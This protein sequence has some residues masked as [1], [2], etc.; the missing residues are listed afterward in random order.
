[1]AAEKLI[2]SAYVFLGLVYAFVYYVRYG[3]GLRDGAPYWNALYAGDRFIMNIALWP[4]MIVAEIKLYFMFRN[5]TLGKQ[6]E[7]K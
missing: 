2:A 1:M 3:L 4:L 6:T 5:F 7:K